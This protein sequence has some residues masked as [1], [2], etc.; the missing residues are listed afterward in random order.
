MLGYLEDDWILQQNVPTDGGE[1]DVEPMEANAIVPVDNEI[2]PVENG[3]GGG[4][5]EEEAIKQK[6]NLPWVEDESED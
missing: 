6:V 1:T 3:D 5:S 2:A 4:P